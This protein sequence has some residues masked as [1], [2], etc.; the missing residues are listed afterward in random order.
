MRPAVRQNLMRGA[1]KVLNADPFA[2]MDR[3]AEKTHVSR[4]TLFRAFKNRS[5]LIEALVLES[6][7]D[8]SEVISRITTGPGTATEKLEQS[9]REMIPLGPMFRF[10]LYGPWLFTNPVINDNEIALHRQWSNLLKI[11]QDDGLLR[12]DLS[13]GWMARCLDNLLMAAWQAL[14][15]G[16]LAL[17]TAH[18]DVLKIFYDG[19]LSQKR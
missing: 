18:E 15:A 9:V 19:I 7:K 16:D 17:N 10:L 14:D 13:P 1:I 2:S 11:L 12:A 4:M 3:I 6:Y 5:G 8:C